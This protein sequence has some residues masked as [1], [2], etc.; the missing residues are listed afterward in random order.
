MVLLHIIDGGGVDL[1]H[2]VYHVVEREQ[3]ISKD[4]FK[5]ITNG[6]YRVLAYDIKSNGILELGRTSPAISERIDIDGVGMS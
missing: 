4:E 2:S 3:L 1:S 6:M 5:N